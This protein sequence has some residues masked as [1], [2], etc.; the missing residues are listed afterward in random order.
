VTNRPIIKVGHRGAA[1]HAPENTLA[2]LER[3][4]ELGADFLEIDVQRT[5]DGRIVLMHDKFVDRTTDG[6]GKLTGMSLE[7]VR[8]LD[9][10]NRQRVPLLQEALELADG[11]AG[12]IVECITP[13]IG[14][15]VYWEVRNCGFRRPVIFSSFLHKEVLA[16]RALDAKAM[17]MALLEAV[18]IVQTAFA[19]ESGATH[20][21]IALDSMTAGFSDALHYAGFEVFI[22]TADTT[23][24]IDLA[25]GF[26][27]DG[28]VS[29][30]PERI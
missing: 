23:Q 3:G 18:P 10:G 5:R 26:G 13:G 27:V 4:I 21:G 29:N 8:R 30:F 25:K 15:E 22:Y 19:Q 14:P 11:R 1:G 6:T 7:E 17:T 20:A 24:Q 12:V 16:I 9:A 28:I 2:A